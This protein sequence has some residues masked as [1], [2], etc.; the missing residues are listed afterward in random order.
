M[1]RTRLF[2]AMLAMIW[3]AAIYIAYTYEL[4][5]KLGFLKKHVQSEELS[6]V[7]IGQSTC[8]DK[9]PQS[10]RVFN[11]DTKS[12]LQKI[13]STAVLEVDNQHTYPVFAILTDAQSGREYQGV[14][15][16]SGQTTRMQIS[17]GDY[18]FIVLAG[19]R[20]C[21]PKLGFSDGQVLQHPEVLSLEKKSYAKMNLLSY[22][23]TPEALIFSYAPAGLLAAANS[24]DILELSRQIDGHFYVVGSVDGHPITFLIDTGATSVSIPYNVATAIGLDKNCMPAYFITAAGRVQ[25][26]KAIVQQLSVAGF[27]FSNM[28]VGFNK[29]GD[30]PLLGMSVLSQFRVQQSGDTMLILRD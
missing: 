10:G 5:A 20:W 19:T 7:L 8:D 4:P 26:C 12:H 29:G 17:A 18:G 16:A 23:S 22:G 6:S 14:Y 21:N 2:W 30:M 24:G 1:T 28:E 13:Q 15:L 25:G 11:I 9:P 27:Q 3:A